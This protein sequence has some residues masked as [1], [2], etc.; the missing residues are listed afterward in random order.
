MVYRGMNENKVAFSIYGN[1]V[2]KK[3]SNDNDV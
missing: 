3:T 2:G 1:T